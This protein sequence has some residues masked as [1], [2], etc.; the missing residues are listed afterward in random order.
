M[1]PLTSTLA[2]NALPG[3]GQHEVIVES[4]RHVAS[5]SQL[6]DAEAETTF[7]AYHD[8]LCQL[9]A[10]GLYRYAQIFKNMGPSAGASL[11]SW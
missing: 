10:S 6:T 2:D 5:L 9:K 7:A 1:A 4:P 11:T 8:R 3:F